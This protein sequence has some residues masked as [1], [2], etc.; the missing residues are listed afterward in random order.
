VNR[1]HA[2]A[3]GKDAPPGACRQCA[4][5]CRK[6]GPAFHRQ[7]RE[8]ID[9]GR[10]PAGHLFT[11]RPGEPAVDNVS[12][13]LSPAAQDIIKIKGK[14]DGSWTC[15]YLDEGRNRCTIYRH[16]PLEC[17]VLKCWAP[18]ELQAVYDRDRLSRRDLLAG[19]NGLWRLICD[20]HER[21]DH[22]RMQALVDRLKGDRDDDVARSELSEMIHYDRQIRLLTCRKA[23]VAAERLDF[24]FGRPLSATLAA[25]GIPLT[26]DGNGNL[27]MPL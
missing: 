17:R 20:H 21:C 8:L 7:D 3:P 16:R 12:G 24:L 22:L 6:G 14:G 10:I 25:M 15:T 9:S 4:T 19:V 18:G 13:I 23:G 11:I 27:R 26:Q 2:P 5:C 1:P